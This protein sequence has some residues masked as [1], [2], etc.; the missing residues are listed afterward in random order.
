L[1]DLNRRL[2]QINQDKKLAQ[3]LSDKFLALEIAEQ[4][5]LAELGPPRPV[6][7]LRRAEPSLSDLN[8]RLEEQIDQDKKL[9]Q[10]L[11]DKFLALEIAEQE[12]LAELLDE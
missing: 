4:E 3:K 7:P 5:R 12:R 11:S 10:E 9:A 1:S 2:E 8:R 6:P